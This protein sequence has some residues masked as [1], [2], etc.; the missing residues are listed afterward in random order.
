MSSEPES[1]TQTDVL[2]LGASFAG[3]EFV[4]Q[5]RRARG[6]REPS[7]VVVDRQ[8]EHLYLPLVHE[9]IAGRGP[10][11]RRLLPT[12]RVL[13]ERY[14][15]DF[16]RGVVAEF[17]PDTKT[18]VLESG[19][20]I[21]GR[22]VVV[23][24]GSTITPPPTIPGHDRLGTFKFLDGADRLRDEGLAGPVVVVGGGLTGVELAAELVAT[25][26]RAVTLVEAGDRL[27]SG[28]HPRWGRH[29]VK[30]LR[31]QGVVVEL[32]TRLVKAGD[33]GVVVEGQGGERTLPCGTAVWAGGVRPAPVV[34]R[35]GLPTDDRGWIRVG[36]TLQCFPTAPDGRTGIFAC[37]DIVRVHGGTGPWPTMQRAIECLWQA[38][39]A[40]RNVA[41][42][43]GAE[44]DG[45]PAL[46][47][48]VLRR[49]FPHGVSLG[50]TSWAVYG[51]LH[52][53]VPG[54]NH[55]FRRW[56]MARYFAR[57]GA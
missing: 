21:A 41:A 17:L 47:P 19:E 13:R 29:A 40:A 11:A 1:T 34:G 49:D 30:V 43:R 18:V 54:L 45:Y 53:S 27:L 23:A 31:R 44:Q 35:L 22:Y 3:L 48:H 10:A 20:R 38:K 33:D 42:M 56:L 4:H 55:W 8:T 51:P 6:G 46:R 57:Y 32:G 24:L 7:I 50:R 5:L 37:G 14:R 26:G 16:R 2:V 25:R 39:V 52:V 15:T 28:L 9:R 12:A 36:P